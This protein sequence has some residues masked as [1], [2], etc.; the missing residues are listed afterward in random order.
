EADQPGASAARAGPAGG[1]SWRTTG[2]VREPIS[3]RSAVMRSSS[4]RSRRRVLAV[5]FPNST[6]W[7]SM[8]SSTAVWIRSRLAMR[9][10][11]PCRGPGGC[12]GP[13][14]LGAAAAAHGGQ[15]VPLLGGGTSGG[16]VGGQVPAEDGF[17]PQGQEQG[18][19][20]QQHEDGHLHGEVVAQEAGQGVVG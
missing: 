18:D 3:R 20:P 8:P 11:A 4:S 13:P 12:V 16:A 17:P 2:A 10:R 14:P 6:L 7:R 1:C 9:A 19:R 5:G 15:E